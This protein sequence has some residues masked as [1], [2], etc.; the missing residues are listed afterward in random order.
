MNQLESEG[1]KISER[2]NWKQNPSFVL[3][4]ILI[5]IPIL[6]VFIFFNYYNLDF[7]AYTGWIILACSI[8]FI[9]LAGGEFRKRVEH[10]KEK[11]LLKPQ[12]LLIVECML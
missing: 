8:I 9:F 4:S 10:Q 3:Y 1:D 11:V 12:F 7:L 2:Y 6:M 5:A